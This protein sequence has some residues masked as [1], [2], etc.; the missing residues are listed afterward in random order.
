M[1]KNFSSMKSPRSISS[2][3]TPT[4]SD[5]SSL[6]IGRANSI[7]R[8]MNAYQVRVKVSGH[9]SVLPSVENPETVDA[10]A[11]KDKKPWT[12]HVFAVT[13]AQRRSALHDMALGKDAAPVPR[14][15]F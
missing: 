2:I 11:D 13:Q 15:C 1:R 10:N 4:F 12:R 6:I 3:E 14:T 9:G 5:M 8:N 7:T